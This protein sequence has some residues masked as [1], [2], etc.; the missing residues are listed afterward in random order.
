MPDFFI[1]SL[2]KAN[3]S[4]TDMDIYFSNHLEYF[5]NFRQAVVYLNND[6]V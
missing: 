1:N 4:L 2:I 6:I 3:F 5:D